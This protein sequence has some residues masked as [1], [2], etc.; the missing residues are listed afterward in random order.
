MSFAFVDQTPI[1][2]GR[3][4]AVSGLLAAIL[5]GLLAWQ[6]VTLFTTP[7][8]P[9][10]DS[11]PLRPIVETVVGAG[12]AR[13]ASP[14]QNAVLVLIDGPEK[15]LPRPKQRKIE[16]LIRASDAGIETIT[17][18]QFPF[19]ASVSVRPQGPAIAEFAGLGIATALS[20]WLALTH[21]RRS[22]TSSPMIAVPSH[23]ASTVS[24][25]TDGPSRPSSDLTAASQIAMGDPNH[26][27]AVIH[28]WLRGKGNAA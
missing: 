28:T 6:G 5:F 3:L 18:R 13:I 10:G 12:H 15:V 21:V 9:Q 1:S 19:A 24:K 23:E 16:D 17:I 8:A 26:I 27:A 4:T 22:R 20:I 7:A 14:T 11:H 25:P 2:P